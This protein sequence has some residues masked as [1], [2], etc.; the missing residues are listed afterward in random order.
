MLYII[1]FFYQWLLPPACIILALVILNIYMY[2]KKS[3]GRYWLSVFIVLFYFFSLRAGA[4]LLVK[5]LEDMYTPPAVVNGDVLIML[6]NGSVGGVPDIDGVGQPSGTMAKSMLFA[7]RLQ[8]MTDLPLLISGGT[9][10][11]DNGTEADIAGREFRSMGIPASKLFLEDKSR[12]TVE[13]ARFSQKICREHGWSRPVLLVVAAQ[14]YRSA[15]IFK[16]EGLACVIYPTHYRRNA[17]WH[18]SFMQDL[19]PQADNMDD[20]AMALKEYMGIVALK[21][22]LQ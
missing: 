22:S 16:R 6:G 18:F 10:F 11:A 8:R 14:A 21:L 4:D 20:S 3:K 17:E 12:N 2:R 7:L 9:V 19:L 5:P 15:L 1:K 13:N